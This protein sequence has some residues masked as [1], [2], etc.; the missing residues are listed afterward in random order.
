MQASLFPIFLLVERPEA[1]LEY[2]NTEVTGLGVEIPTPYNGQGTQSW[3]SKRL[4]MTKEG[5]L[6][7]RTN[8]HHNHHHQYI[9]I[10]KYIDKQQ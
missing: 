2:T 7:Q 5:L 6:F 9:T 1:Y 3:N 10:Q 4:R 8:Y